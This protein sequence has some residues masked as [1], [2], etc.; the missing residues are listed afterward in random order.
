MCGQN[1]AR[2]KVLLSEIVRGLWGGGPGVALK[3][4]WPAPPCAGGRQGGQHQAEG[5][6]MDPGSYKPKIIP[7][8]F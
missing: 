8:V 4:C 1:L 5:M 7:E 2:A 6:K 3:I